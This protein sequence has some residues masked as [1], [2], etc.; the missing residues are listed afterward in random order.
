MQH[1]IL[2]ILRHSVFN[3]K[4]GSDGKYTHQ[5]RRLVF[6]ELVPKTLQKMI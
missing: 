4:V 1:P 2:M 6:P 3:W 5:Q